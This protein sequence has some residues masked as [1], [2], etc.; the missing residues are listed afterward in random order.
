MIEGF[1]AR[2]EMSLARGHRNQQWLDLARNIVRADRVVCPSPS[3]QYNR[4]MTA[5]FITLSVLYK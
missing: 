1:S 2:N 5:I 4:T 3:Q